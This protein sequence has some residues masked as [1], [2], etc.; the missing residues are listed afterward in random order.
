MES[1]DDRDKFIHSIFLL[2]KI[3]ALVLSEI[4]VR[5]MIE[6]FEIL[7]LEKL[8]FFTYCVNPILVSY[9]K[10]NKKVI[11]FSIKKVSICICE[12]CRKLARIFKNVRVKLD[13]LAEDYLNLA[14]EIK[15]QINDEIFIKTIYLKKGYPSPNYS[16]LQI[17]NKDTTF[18]SPLLTNSVVQDT[19]SEL[20]ISQHYYT[21]NIFNTS[22]SFQ[23]LKGKIFIM[24]NI[25]NDSKDLYTNYN[26]IQNTK[27]QSTSS[28]SNDRK[29]L[30]PNF[31]KFQEDSIKL[32]Q[33]QAIDFKKPFH[34]IRKSGFH[35]YRFSNH[36]FTYFFWRK[37]PAYKVAIEVVVP[38]PNN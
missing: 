18:Y 28:E 14:V 1:A 35:D 37:S 2:N 17:L 26:D 32:N 33:L 25:N 5:L 34:F 8:Y 4:H 29:N 19:I 36:I 3:E 23:N 15:N 10:I 21:L 38:T 12:F 7:W 22:S 6:K 16:L 24:E 30:N 9:I 27:V 13:Q 20:W 11:Y 31:M